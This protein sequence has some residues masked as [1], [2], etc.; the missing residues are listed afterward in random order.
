M[1]HSLFDTLILSCLF[2]N[3]KKRKQRKKRKK[4]PPKTYSNC[5]GKRKNES[6]LSDQILI[7][8]ACDSVSRITFEIGDDLLRLFHL[9]AI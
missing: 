9:T 6:F 3:T 8:T 1:T 4:T 7:M 5:K 2:L